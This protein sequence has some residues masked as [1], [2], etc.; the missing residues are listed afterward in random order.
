MQQPVKRRN[1]ATKGRSAKRKAAT[2]ASSLTAKQVADIVRTAVLSL[3]GEDDIDTDATL[4]DEGL[5]SL[6]ATELASR[7]SA[8]L[9][10]RVPPTFIFSY[11][12]MKQICEYM[13]ELLGLTESASDDAAADNAS[14]FT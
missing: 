13:E 7:L 2:A 3:V 10:V 5:D 9:D 14:F 8:D 11:P 12:T 4:M 1:A 6:G